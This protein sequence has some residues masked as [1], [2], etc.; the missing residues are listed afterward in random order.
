MTNFMTSKQ[1]YSLLQRITISSKVEHQSDIGAEVM[2]RRELADEWI[3][4]LIR[5][6]S[7][8]ARLRVD[9]LSNFVL[10]YEDL[11]LKQLTSAGNEV[12]FKPGEALGNLFCLFSNLIGSKLEAGL[13]G[14]FSRRSNLRQVLSFAAFYKPLYEPDMKGFSHYIFRN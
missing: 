6:D 11:S 14:S 2:T 9:P 5:P 1:T 13:S 10:G 8:L 7:R 4:T 3:S 12:G